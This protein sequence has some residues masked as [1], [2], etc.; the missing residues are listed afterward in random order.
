MTTTQRG[1]KKAAA[2]SRSNTEIRA[3]VLRYFY[4]RNAASTSV[5]GKKGYAVKISDVRKETFGFGGQNVQ[6][7]LSV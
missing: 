2:I 7:I 5:R 3:I 4:D 1:K 6:R